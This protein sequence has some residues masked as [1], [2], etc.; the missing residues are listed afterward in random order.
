MY[1]DMA[2]LVLSMFSKWLFSLCLGCYPTDKPEKDPY[3]K[4]P[5]TLNSLSQGVIGSEFLSS[6]VCVKPA[7]FRAGHRCLGKFLTE[8][9]SGFTS[10][11]CFCDLVQFLVSQ[12]ALFLLSFVAA[13]RLAL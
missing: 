4:S 5:V 9:L 3:L 12:K 11:Y 7:C 13:F 10:S 8:G 1:K 6:Q 2:C